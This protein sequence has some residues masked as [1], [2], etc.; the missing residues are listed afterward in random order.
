MMPWEAMEE[1]KVDGIDSM[2]SSSCT[3][4]CCNGLYALVMDCNNGHCYLTCVDGLYVMHCMH[5]LCV[6]DVFVVLSMCLVMIC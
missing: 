6:F 1:D 5:E 3:C 4:R 2:N